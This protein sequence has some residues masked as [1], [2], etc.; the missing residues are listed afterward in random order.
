MSKTVIAL[1][2]VIA[3]IVLGGALRPASALTHNDQNNCY[4][5]P[6]PCVS[7]IISGGGIGLQGISNGGGSGVGVNAQRNGPAGFA[8]QATNSGGGAGVYALGNPGAIADNT[9]NG[10]GLAAVGSPALQATSSSSGTL[11]YQ[12]IGPKG[13]VFRVN[14]HGDGYFAGKVVGAHVSE[15]PTA[16][17]TSVTTYAGQTTSP[18]IEDFGEAQLAGGRAYVR[19]DARFASAIQSAKYLVF[20]TPQGPVSG[21]V[22]VAQK[23]AMGFAIR[24]AA[25][26]GSNVAVDYRIVAQPFGPAQPRLPAVSTR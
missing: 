8:L 26:D 2:A 21:T 18:V 20:L 10:I 3:A 14:S 19:F 25:R 7:A 6:G 15:Q 23:S 16:T 4:G 13:V 12:G 11:L 22:Y 5:G 9:G 1:A 24:E 17:G